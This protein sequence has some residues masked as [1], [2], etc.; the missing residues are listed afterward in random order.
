M[1]V[2]AKGPI[3]RTAPSQPQER[4]V[5]DLKKTLTALEQRVVEWSREKFE[6]P[7][8]VDCEHGCGITLSKYRWKELRKEIGTPI[9]IL[10]RTG[11]ANL[12][13]NRN[14]A[15]L[16]NPSVSSPSEII[17][18][19][20]EHITLEVRE[21]IEALKKRIEAP[22]SKA[23][24]DEILSSLAAVRDKAP[25]SF[26]NEI[27][28]LASRTFTKSASDAPIS[29]YSLQAPVQNPSP[30]RVDLPVATL[31]AGTVEVL[32]PSTARKLM[33][34][35]V[36]NN[37][38]EEKNLERE[39][40]LL[41]DK[42]RLEVLRERKRKRNEESIKEEKVLA[43]FANDLQKELNGVENPIGSNVQRETS[44]RAPAAAASSSS[45]PSHPPA[46]KRPRMSLET[47]AESSIPEA[48]I[49]QPVPAK[50]PKMYSQPP[51]PATVP[52]R[53]RRPS[54][55]GMTL[56]K[57]IPRSQRAQ[58]EAS[59]LESSV[60]IKDLIAK[61]PNELILEKTILTILGDN[62]KISPSTLKSRLIALLKKQ[63]INV[64]ITNFLANSIEKIVKSFNPEKG[65]LTIEQVKSCVAKINKEY[66][67]WK[68]KILS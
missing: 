40:L 61:L 29:L 67:E 13:F 44:E 43:Q 37:E 60:D 45:A 15:A 32:S 54:T 59:L 12:I 51:A 46:A 49:P 1:Q 52:T 19:K 33:D 64:E 9:C 48:P 56:P 25:P 10:C 63:S 2:P 47:S 30:S 14:F 55:G 38:E 50:R 21:T 17:A 65:M 8:T 24:K 16:R 7:Y 35:V 28:G 4:T 22:F 53:V 26:Y 41:D 42:G 66:Q 20:E 6:D 34:I 62:N 5:P 36:D 11:Y 23:E 58:E 31:E 27:D 18:S 3:E 39:L 68:S 57:A